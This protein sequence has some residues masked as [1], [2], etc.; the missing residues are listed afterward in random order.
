M[1]IYALHGKCLVAALETR[2][3]GGETNRFYKLEIQKSA[4]SRSSRPEPAIWLPVNTA[5]ERGLREIMSPA[6]AEVVFAILNS[7][8]YYFSIDEAWNILQSKLET[9]IRLEGAAGMA[10]VVS[11][12]HVLKKRQIVPTPEVAKLDTLVHKLMMRELVE[13]MGEQPRAIDDRITK[14]LRHKLLPDH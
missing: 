2:T 1:A 9:T 3:V 8:E 11:F 6:Q 4:L 10:K 14:A 7:R 13:V 5:R 12:L